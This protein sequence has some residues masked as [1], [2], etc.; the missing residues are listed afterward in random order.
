MSEVISGCQ[1]FVSAEGMQ[2]KTIETKRTRSF[3]SFVT[4]TL[5]GY[6]G[7][8]PGH[9]RLVIVAVGDTCAPNIG[10]VRWERKR[11]E[12]QKIMLRGGC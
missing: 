10:N 2:E 11:A 1:S 8:S 5:M 9:T 6:T 7:H 4:H 12:R 3:H